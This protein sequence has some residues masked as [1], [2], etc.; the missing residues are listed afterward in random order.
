M[1]PEGLS[2]FVWGIYIAAI[3]FTFVLVPNTF[4]RMFRFE[5]TREPWIRVLGVILLDL[6]FL[7]VVCG[8]KSS[9]TFVWASIVVRYWVLVGFV[10]LVL[11][12]QAKAQLIL[13]GVVD[14]LGATWTLLVRQLL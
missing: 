1:N 8:L 12:R 14:A 10:A 13:F 3:G 4:L 7:Y 6:A 9:E 5:E 11:A 2:V